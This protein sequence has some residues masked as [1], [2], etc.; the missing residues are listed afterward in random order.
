MIFLHGYLADKRSF[1]YQYP[2]FEKDFKVYSL[3]FKGFGEN[4]GMEY[5]YSLDDYVRDFIAFI[6][7]NE[8]VKPNVVAHSFGGR[9]ALKTAY[10][11]PELLDKLVLTGCAGLKPKKTFKKTI[12]SLGYKIVKP[13]LSKKARLKFY[14]EDYRKLSPVM[15][16]SFVKIVNEHLDY[17]L[18]GIKNE[19]FIV[20][21]KND[22]E[23]PTYMADKLA[24]KIHKSHKL[25]I[26][27][28]GHFCFVDN[29]YKFNTEV[30]EFLLSKD[31]VSVKRR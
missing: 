16:E 20:F 7:E 11:Y 27:R 31:Y 25:I 21:G 1:A 23:T 19:C 6:K 2:Y 24:D 29:P 30:R 5:P 22:S 17:T 8:I 26:D 14:S 12:K 10:L 15:R 18:D 3:D 13:F 28:A 4:V 9:V